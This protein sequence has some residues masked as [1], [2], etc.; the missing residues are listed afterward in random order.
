[1]RSLTFFTTFAAA[2]KEHIFGR[3]IR[4]FY[5]HIPL[6]QGLRQVFSRIKANRRITLRAYSIKTRIKTLFPVHRVLN[7]F[8]L[9]EHIPLKQENLQTN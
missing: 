5:S 4:Y 6:K 2:K 8:C 9:L 7:H 1:M 3:F